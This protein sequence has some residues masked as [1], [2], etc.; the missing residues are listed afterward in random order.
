MS[1]VTTSFSNWDFNSQHVQQNLTGGNFVGSHTVIVCATAPRLSDLAVGGA[2]N[3]SGSAPNIGGFTRSS[4]VGAT[5]N[6]FAIPLGVVSDFTINQNR[7]LQQIFELGSKRSYFLTARNLTSLGL[8]RVFFSGPSLL[9]MLYAYYP[10]ANIGGGNAGN[11]LRDV[12]SCPDS[13][14]E[15]IKFKGDGCTDIPNISTKDLPGFDNFFINLASTL[16][17]Q[18]I[19]LVMYVRDNANKDIGAVFFEEC[20]IEAHQMGMSQGSVVVGEGV[21]IRCDRIVPIRVQ[22]STNLANM[23][24][25]SPVSQKQT[26]D[27]VESLSSTGGVAKGLS[28]LGIAIPGVG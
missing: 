14:I 27:L 6:G 22:V 5:Q 2:G 19:G 26:T 24:A 9:R 4:S 21:Q 7:Q 12:T 15:Q 17:S 11:S 18:P 28:A 8:S 10:E 3:T 13:K 16:F 1:K 20:N 25:S 23:A